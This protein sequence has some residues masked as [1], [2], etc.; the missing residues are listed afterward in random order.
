MHAT[1]RGSKESAP[2]SEVLWQ[3][4]VQSPGWRREFAHPGVSRAPQCHTLL[5][6]GI[7][8]LLTRL[9]AAAFPNA[10]AQRETSSALA[11]F[12]RTLLSPGISSCL[13]HHRCGSNNAAWSQLVEHNHE[14]SAKFHSQGG[15]TEPPWQH[16]PGQVCSHL[17][18]CSYCN[19]EA[20]KREFSLLIQTTVFIHHKKYLCVFKSLLVIFHMSP[21]MDSESIP[22]DTTPAVPCRKNRTCMF[23]SRL[24]LNLL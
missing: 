21:E 5:V 7:W 4:W 2:G 15:N 6:V 10:W 14:P 13:K 8:T 23:S 18:S 17:G 16:S 3:Q 20:G 22:G 9:P 11:G 19:H 24:Y 1:V 12:V